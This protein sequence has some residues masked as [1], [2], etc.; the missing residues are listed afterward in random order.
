MRKT[1]RPL[2]VEAL[3]D[4]I[5]TSGIDVKQNAI[6]YIFKCPRCDKS[7]KLYI[8][9]RDGRF[10]CWVC[11]GSSNYEGYRVDLPLSE[12]LGGKRRD[13]AKL[14]WGGDTDVLSNHLDLELVDHFGEF[15]D[16]EDEFMG[17]P[18]LEVKG[19]DMFEHYPIDH[20]KAVTGAAYLLKRGL[21]LDLAKVLDIRYSM[22]QNRVCFPMVIDG[23][24]YGWQ[25]R[26]CGDN[27]HIHKADT[28]LSD[29]VAGHFVMFGDV[30]SKFGRAI[31]VEGPMDALKLSYCGGA[32]AG[33]GKGVTRAQIQWLSERCKTLYIGLDRDA[34]AEI[35][36]MMEYA[37]GLG[38]ATW[39]LQPPSHR[40]DFGD[41]TFAEA[42]ASFARAVPVHTSQLIMSLGDALIS[43]LHSD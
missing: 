19:W 11:A 29:H 5:E 4:I 33:L 10:T 16:D 12:L 27:P 40:K 15:D 23:K 20:P 1:Y 21:D 26:Y 17:E 35:N 42:A 39:L 18:P 2:N 7:N 8:R 34:G 25:G 6:S 36:K 24:Q 22:R 28:M 38:M 30:V 3:K 9:K 14:L 31:L 41:C 43:P 32:V 13:Y 37:Q